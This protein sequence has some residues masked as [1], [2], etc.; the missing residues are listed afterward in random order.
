[1]LL[2]TLNPSLRV[3]AYALACPSDVPKNGASMRLYT[4]HAANDGTGTSWREG[5]DLENIDAALAE[6]SDAIAPST[7]ANWAVVAQYQYEDEGDGRVPETRSFINRATGKPAVGGL[8][9]LY[10]RRWYHRLFGL[11]GDVRVQDMDVFGDWYEAGKFS[12]IY[13]GFRAPLPSEH[14]V[15]IKLGGDASILQNPSPALLRSMPPGCTKRTETASTRAAALW[16]LCLVW[17]GYVTRAGQPTELFTP[18][19]SKP[20]EVQS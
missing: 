1:M 13:T 7:G 11:Y 15:T 6:F 19:T 12:E 4:E 18:T 5:A 14:D 20:V 17:H 10:R 3:R 9:V 16:L 8:R 2:N